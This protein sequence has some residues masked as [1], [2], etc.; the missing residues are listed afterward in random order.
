MRNNK[1]LKLKL[2]VEQDANA[3]PRGGAKKQYCF[4]LAL[5]LAPLGVFSFISACSPLTSHRTD[6]EVWREYQNENKNLVRSPAANVSTA[7]E[8]LNEALDKISI[9]GVLFSCMG[10]NSMDA[11]FSAKLTLLFDEAARGV[12]EL[13]A[14]QYKKE[15]KKYLET[16]TYSMVYRQVLGF[17]QQLLSGIDFRASDRVRDLV[18]ECEKNQSNQNLNLSFNFYLGGSTFVPKMVFQCINSKWSQNEVNLLSE[19]SNRLGLRFKNPMAKEFIILNLIRPVFT[20]ELNTLLQ[21]KSEDEEKNWK[22]NLENLKEK[23]KFSTQLWKNDEK[24]CVTKV[25]QKYTPELRQ[26][27]AYFNLESAVTEIAK[28]KC[29]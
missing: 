5:F 24:D 4:L 14:S 20:L 2:S 21:K 13:T 27:Y 12:P 6:D 1:A 23:I 16:K 22:L 9:R 18:S 8:Q 10:T 25:V 29:K 28:E 3:K 17:Y 11:C 7:V 15:Q 19:T 26:N